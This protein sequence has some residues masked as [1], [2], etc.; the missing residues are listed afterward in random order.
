MIYCRKI[1][2][3]KA[4]NIC[5]LFP[6][7]GT[8]GVISE[9]VCGAAAGLGLPQ[10]VDAESHGEQVQ[11]LVPHRPAALL[12]QV[13]DHRALVLLVALVRVLQTHQELAAR[14]IITCLQ[15]QVCLTLG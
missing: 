1:Y 14:N 10:R 15:K 2:F 11:A 13:D 6:P 8:A 3:Y 7:A 9:E 5:K 4:K 12:H